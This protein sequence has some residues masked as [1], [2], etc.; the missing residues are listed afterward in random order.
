M[1]NVLL[2]LLIQ[3]LAISSFADNELDPEKL[4]KDHMFDVK[5]ENISDVDRHIEEIYICID[6]RC[7]YSLYEKK[8]LN[9][10]CNESCEFKGF[11]IKNPEAFSVYLWFKDKNTRRLRRINDSTNCS[12]KIKC[13]NDK[14]QFTFEFL[15]SSKNFD[16]T[17]NGPEIVTD[18][19]RTR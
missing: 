13:Q 16:G 17:T 12:V 3:L 2:I 15:K 18:R 10:Y 11:Y 5:V 19:M 9:N 14:F 4:L 6:G 8:E 1:K 7:K